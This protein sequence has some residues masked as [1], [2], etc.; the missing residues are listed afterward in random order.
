MK[1]EDEVCKMNNNKSHKTK[2]ITHIKKIN[3]TQTNSHYNKSL[4]NQNKYQVGTW[5][6]PK[7]KQSLSRRIVNKLPHFQSFPS[8]IQASIGSSISSITKERIL[9]IILEH[10]NSDP[11][12]IQTSI[13]SNMS[14]ITKDKPFK[15]NNNKVEQFLNKWKHRKNKKT[16]IQNKLNKQSSN[17]ETTTHF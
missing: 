16:T 2:N 3:K 13:G 14:S 6:K 8:I 15:K 11:S 7:L 17:K 9:D 4:W 1:S 5:S 12:I 10:F